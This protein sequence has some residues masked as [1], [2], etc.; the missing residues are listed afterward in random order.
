MNWR[1]LFESLPDVVA[2]GDLPEAIG[3]IERAKWILVS[4]LNDAGDSSPLPP[5]TT[6]KDPEH[7]QLLTADEVARR[8]GVRVRFVYDNADD[9]PF[10]RRLGPR[11][12]RFSERGLRRYI[13]TRRA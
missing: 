8:L 10:T 6:T 3:A 13:E 7:D 11:T 9:W 1:T 12:L 2:P 4:R 5:S